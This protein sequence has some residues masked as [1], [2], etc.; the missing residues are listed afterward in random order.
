M[1]KVHHSSELEQVRFAEVLQYNG[2]QESQQ[3][4]KLFEVLQCSDGLEHQLAHMIMLVWVLLC[5]VLLVTRLHMERMFILEHD[6]E[7]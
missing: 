2:G 1:I 7:D 4:Q 3:E 6:I 5:T